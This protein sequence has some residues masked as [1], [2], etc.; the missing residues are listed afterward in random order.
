MKIEG[1][2]PQEKHLLM[3][4]VYSYSK[5]G[6]H[7]FCFNETN[8]VFQHLDVEE[9]VL[10]LNNLEKSLN[11]FFNENNNQC[12]VFVCNIYSFALMQTSH[13]FFLFNSYATSYAGEPMIS[14][15]KDSA[16]CSMEVFTIRCLSNHLLAACNQEQMTFDCDEDGT[17]I[18]FS[19]INL[20]IE[21]KVFGKDILKRKKVDRHLCVAERNRGGIQRKHKSRLFQGKEELVRFNL[22]HLT[23]SK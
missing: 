17:S 9:D 21:K 7:F 2:K 18:C 19:L 5:I 13:S 20:G 11:R 23:I 4:E 3:S 15:D 10:N 1:K 8:N 14:N 6:G 16:A 22:F 12:G